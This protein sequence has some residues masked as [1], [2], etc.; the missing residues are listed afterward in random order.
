MSLTIIV[1]V[2]LC[3]LFGLKSFDVVLI[4]SSHALL[5]RHNHR[6]SPPY[7]LSIQISRLLL[8]YHTRFF[9]FLVRIFRS[10]TSPNLPAYPISRSPLVTFTRN[11]TKLHT[12]NPQD[13]PPPPPTTPT[14][15]STYQTMHPSP[16]LLLTVLTLLAVSQIAATAPPPSSSALTEHVRQFQ[17]HS[18]SIQTYTD[19]T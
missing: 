17:A 16:P 18:K 9:L 12:T 19:M 6:S 5:S 3:A 2:R 13:P 4:T 15:R 14:P 11:C 1:E 7:L 10:T 8:E